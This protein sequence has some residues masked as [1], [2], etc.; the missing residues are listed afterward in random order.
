M[1][2]RADEEALVLRIGGETD[3]RTPLERAIDKVEAAIK[4]RRSSNVDSKMIYYM[5]VSLDAVFELAL[6]HLKMLREREKS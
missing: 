6:A 4:E 2:M 5:E 1:T 3:T